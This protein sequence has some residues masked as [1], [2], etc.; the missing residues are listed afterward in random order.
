MESPNVSIVDICKLKVTK[1]WTS[2]ARIRFTDIGK[3]TQLYSE[4]Y[5]VPEIKAEW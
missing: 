1:G 5:K 4:T 3:K 2:K